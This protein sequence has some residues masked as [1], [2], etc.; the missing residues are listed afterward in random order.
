M[1]FPTLGSSWAYDDIDYIN[2]AADTMADRQ[3]FLDLLLRPQAEHIVAG[4]RIVQYAS[5][6]LFGVAA[7]PFRLLVLI[8]HATSAF[9]LGLLAWR[10]SRSAAAALAAGVTYA[11]ACGFSS[12]WI[13]FPAGSTVPFAMAALTGG[14]VALAWR[15]YL[16]IG[17]ARL[18]AGAAV[19]AA[20]LW[21]PRSS[22]RAHSRLWRSCPC[23]STNMKG[24]GRVPAGRSASSR[25]S[26]CSPRLPWRSW[27]RSSTCGRSGPT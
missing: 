2:Q 18:L 16:G 26:A 3:G 13:W 1:Y 19:V 15:Q 17:R 9:F 27:P 6:K 5:L 7:F 4:F 10:Y 11:G 23:C 8:A 24:G 20:L 14:L 21:S 25:S 22:L 12:M